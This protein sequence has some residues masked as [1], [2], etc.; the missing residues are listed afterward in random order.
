M[1]RVANVTARKKDRGVL[2]GVSFEIDRGVLAIVGSEGT[3]LLFDVLDGTVKPERG[4]VERGAHVFRISQDAPLPEAFS[5]AEACAFAREVN[6][7]PPRSAEEILGILGIAR[8][9]KQKIATLTREQRRTVAFAIAL[10]SELDLLLVEEPLVAL[11]PEAPGRVSEALRRSNARV[12]IVATASRRDAAALAD[13]RLAMERGTLVA[14]AENPVRSMSV[15]VAPDATAPLTALLARD[16]RVS[17]L[18]SAA[19]EVTVSGPDPEELARSIT[20]AVAS[21]GIEVRR[22][23]RRTA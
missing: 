19:G 2:T 13:R 12:T 7:E 8:Y 1:I 4:T 22:I 21:L 18:A 15:R 20:H 14:A 9:A 23:E 16:P 6:R 11:S 3:S 17:G 5:V 10:A